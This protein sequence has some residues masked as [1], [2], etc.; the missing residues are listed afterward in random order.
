VGV[1]GERSYKKDGTN[2]VFSD[3]KYELEIK[4]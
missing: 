2:L 4:E 1:I 3:Y